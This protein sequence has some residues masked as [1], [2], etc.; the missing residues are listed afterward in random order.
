MTK[1]IF[2]ASLMVLFVYCAPAQQSAQATQQ[3]AQTPVISDQDIKLLREDIQTGRK[4]IVA[5][6]MV[7]TDVEAQK[8]WPLYD[9]YATEAAKI[10]DAKVDVIKDYAA[11]YQNLS[12]DQAVALATKWNQA[13]QSALQLRMKYFPM[14]QKALSGIKAVRFFQVDRRISLLIDVQLASAIPLAQP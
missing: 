13:D 7:L 2:A 9:A 5:V 11:H 4:Q 12:D 14:F 6:N 1:R 10:N 3:G 8:F